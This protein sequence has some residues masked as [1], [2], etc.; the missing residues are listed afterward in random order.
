MSASNPQSAATSFADLLIDASPDALIALSIEGR[1]LWWNHGA[2]AIFGYTSG[3]AIGKSIDALLVPDADRA[4]AQRVL[5]EVTEKGS[6]LFETTRKRKDGSLIHVDVTMRHVDSPGIA[7]FIA[8]SKKD[9]TELRRLQEQQHNAARSKAEDKFRG[10]LEAAP[11]AVVIVGPSGKIVLVNS[12]TERLFGYTRADLIGQ[13][14]EI[15]VPERFRAR[16]PGHRLGYF[17]DPKVRSMGTNLELQ[18]L[19]RDGTEFPVEISLSPL[20]TE[21][22]LLVSSAIRDISERKKAEDKFAGCSKRPP[23]PS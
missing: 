2:E 1:I 19:R 10:F 4:N 13:D 18:G 3:E 16:H 9:V 15:L 11:D 12:Q 14:V 20:E 8:V 7:P 17:S 5:A 22:G 23:T 6:I 21:E